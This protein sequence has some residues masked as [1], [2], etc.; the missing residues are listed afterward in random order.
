L[1]KRFLLERR[2]EEGRGEQQ[3]HK[4]KYKYKE[5]EERGSRSFDEW[6][7]EA[8]AF[9]SH[10]HGSQSGVLVEEA[11]PY[12]GHCSKASIRPQHDFD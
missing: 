3:V 7:H 6:R 8:V 1:K 9:Q 5:D 10:H 12:G 2:E 11:R 4:Y